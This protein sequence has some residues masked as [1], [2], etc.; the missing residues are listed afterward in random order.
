L[1]RSRKI[2]LFL[3]KILIAV[4]SFKDSLD[5]FRACRAIGLGIRAALPKAEIIELPLSDGGE[6]LSDIAA[7][8][9][10]LQQISVEICDPL[11]RKRIAHYGLSQDHSTAFLEMAQAAGLQLLTP[12]E[13][14]PLYT[15]TYG[16]GLMVKDAIAKGATRII[17]GLGGSATNDA[18]MGM[19]AAFGWQFLDKNGSILSPIGGNLGKIA[20]VIPP[21]SLPNI[22]VEGICDVKNPLFGENG[23]A[24]IFARQKGANDQDI[25]YLDNGLRHFAKILNADAHRIG[26]GAA[27]GLGFGCQFFL[28]AF[29]KR[30]IESVLDWAD[31][32]SKTADADY[33]FTGEGRLD[34]QTLQGKLISGIAER[35]KGKPIIALC[36]GLDLKPAD[37]KQLGLKAAFSITQKPCT[38]SEAL[39]ETAQNLEKTA[40]NVAMLLNNGKK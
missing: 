7:Y 38:L 28:N 32:D 31:F 30:G 4:D 16:V 40:Y 29:L 20:Q 34:R 27:G 39:L 17:M 18:G 9:F 2:K 3:M 26:A 35:A 33:I 12:Q 22:T 1:R 21:I 19:A 11:F 37:L 5:T 36:G 8:Y 10:D 25:Q 23:A 14:N 6:G 13:R 24:Y 15:T